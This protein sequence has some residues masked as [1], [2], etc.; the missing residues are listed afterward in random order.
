MTQLLISF[1]NVFPRGLAL[2]IYD[3]EKE[4]FGW[5]SSN[6]LNNNILG[7]NGI[8]IRNEKYFIVTQLQ[9]GGISG[10]I[11]LNKNDLQI[12]DLHLLKKTRDAHSLISHDDGFLITDTGNNRL[13]K[14]I[15]S[16]EETEI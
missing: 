8:S 12:L 16:N 13:V 15:V 14:I 4:E 1:C 3:Y 6:K 10:L 11:T 2:G 9:V 7:F 5:I